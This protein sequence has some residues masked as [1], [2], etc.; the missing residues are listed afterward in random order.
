MGLPFVGLA[1]PREAAD[2][3][4]T[5]VGEL[6][7]V[8]LDAA[9]GDIGQASDVLVGE[10]LAFEPQDLHLLL[11]A[12]MRMMVAVVADRVAVFGGK[13]EVAHGRFLCS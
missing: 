6:V 7:E 2:T 10:T 9:P 3:P 12:R 1:L 13:R 5:A 8:A 11:D 4:P